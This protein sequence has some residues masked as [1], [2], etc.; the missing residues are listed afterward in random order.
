MNISEKIKKIRLDNNFTQETFSS[1]LGVPRYLVSN[2]EQGRSAPSI[3]DVVLI[4]NK[5]NCSIDELLLEEVDYLID[6]S[7]K[8]SILNDNPSLSEEDQN[9]LKRIKALSPFQ[10]KAILIQIEAFE[11][12]NSKKIIK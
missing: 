2:W 11:E 1:F 10:Y 5:L 6:G 12:S 3:E 4:A 8:R 7:S 9:L